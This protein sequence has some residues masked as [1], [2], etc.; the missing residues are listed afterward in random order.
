MYIEPKSAITLLKRNPS[1]YGNPVSFEV[2]E[3]FERAICES[4]YAIDVIR[5]DGILLPKFY[6]LA[7]IKLRVPFY[8]SSICTKSKKSIF[9]IQMGPDFGKILPLIN[10]YE[11]VYA[12]FFDIWPNFFDEMELFLK[13]IPVSQVFLSSA[14]AVNYFRNKGFLNLTWIPEGV[15][16]KS[17]M[18]SSYKNK[19]I[20][21]L[22][23]GRKH[24]HIHN[25]IAE[26]LRTEHKT[27]LFEKKP[28]EIIFSTTEEFVSG[29]ARSKISLCFPKNETHPDVAGSISTMTNRYLQSMAS[30]C[31]V[32]GSA[33]QEM[34][35]LF[36]YNPVIQINFSDPA[37][38][39]LEILDT[40]EDYHSLI[41]KNYQNVIR[42]HTWESRW[43]SILETIK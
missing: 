26:I 4:E 43:K 28:G 14:N 30:K 38:H 12:Y 21:V 9:S 22:E 23:L 6:K 10:R 17:Y 16:S 41:E 5:N 35:Q 33:P 1:L 25:T 37:R 18:Y 2:V 20:D 11:N 31:L 34:I 36:G 27:H 29:M 15:S 13:N 32:V 7:Y 19:D 3:E 40:Y 8:S 42:N 39:L 24:K